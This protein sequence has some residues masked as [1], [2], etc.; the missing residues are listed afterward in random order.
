MKVNLSLHN[1]NRMLKT[2]DLA[3]TSLK[4][5]FI[6]EIVDSG[7]KIKNRAREVLRDRATAG[8][9][10]GRL[11]DSIESKPVIR[12]DN[13]AGVSVGVDLRKA[14]YAEWVEIGHY[15]AVGPFGSERG[16]WWEGY[17]Y[18]ETAF[19]ELGPKLPSQI[20]NTLKVSLKNFDVRSTGFAHKTTGRFV[21]GSAG[22][23]FVN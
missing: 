9:W 11:H 18:L 23:N 5:K 1:Y 15:I 19:A 13:V 4:Q 2:L 14:P 3:E 8:Y 6:D 10:T 21:S 22:F 20:A 17:H 16:R 7:N 12:E